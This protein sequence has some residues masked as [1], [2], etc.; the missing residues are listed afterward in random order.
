MAQMANGAQFVK[1]TITTDNNNSTYTINFGR[2]FN[3]YLFYI[4]MTDASK[5]A[6]INYGSTYAKM[7]AC[8]GMYPAPQIGE[9]TIGQT[10]I[11]RRYKASDGIVDSSAAGI[12]NIGNDFITLANT[13]VSSSSN[14][15]GFMKG[16]SYNY[17]IVEIK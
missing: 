7:Y 15:N 16:Y 6:L 9:A 13:A 12:Y 11:S 10:M 2:T 1:G 17:Y 3:N 5:T 8:C 14:P 4:E